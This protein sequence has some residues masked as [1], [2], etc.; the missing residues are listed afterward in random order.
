MQI[1][2]IEVYLAKSF[3]N[4]PKVMLLDEPTASLDPDVAKYI[5][6]F[7]LETRE[8]QNISVVFTSHNM[9]EVEEICDRVIF[10]QRGKIVAEDTPI[11][12]AKKIR[13]CKI[14]LLITDGQKRTLAYCRKQKIIV[15]VEGRFV[16]VDIREKEIAAFLS[17]L[18]DIGV[19]Y[20]EISI[21]K[22]TLEDFFLK[23]AR[24]N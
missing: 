21:D 3:L 14:H 11:A 13:F 16:S 10:L 7:I 22:P 15:D 18:A 12:L 2:V 20:D 9:S 17:S 5:R 4:S 23:T 8:K 19:E 1:Q 24:G 6:N